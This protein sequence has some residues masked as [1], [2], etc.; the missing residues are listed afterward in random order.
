MIICILHPLLLQQ[1]TRWV[2]SVVVESASSGGYWESGSVRSELSAT[3]SSAWMTS[4]ATEEDAALSQ[5]GGG[6]ARSS[7]RALILQMAKAR[8]KSQVHANSSGAAAGANAVTPQ[9]ED[10]KK[11]SLDVLSS[12]AMDFTNDLD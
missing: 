9:L 3:G 1:Y 6:D 12:D 8:M 11:D 10:E 7:R 4:T 2:A 5:S